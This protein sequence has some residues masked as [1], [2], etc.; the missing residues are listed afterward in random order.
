MKSRPYLT[1][2]LLMGHKESTQTNKLILK[3]EK[4]DKKIHKARKSK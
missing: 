3:K 1:E 2:R 4:I